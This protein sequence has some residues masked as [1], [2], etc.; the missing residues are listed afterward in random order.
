MKT[1]TPVKLA[2]KL[3]KKTMAQICKMGRRLVKKILMARSLDNE[4]ALAYFASRF[5]QVSAEYRFRIAKK[6]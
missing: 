2:L 3:Q 1:K 5:K 4:P 6:P